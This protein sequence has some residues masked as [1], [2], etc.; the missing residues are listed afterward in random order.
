MKTSTLA[1]L[2]LSSSLLA[3][4]GVATAQPSSFAPEVS[5]QATSAAEHRQHS[6]NVS[7]L[8]LVGG[9]FNANYERLRGHHGLLL[10]IG[11][12][13]WTSEYRSTVNG[14]LVEEE[15][16]SGRHATIGVGYRL[17]LSGRQ[18]GWFV[19]AMLHH[20]FGSAEIRNMTVGRPVA[21]DDVA[22][23]STTLTA[24]VGKRWMLIGGLNLT[25]RLGFGAADRQVDDDMADAT[26]AAELQDTLDVPVAVDGE[27]SLGWTF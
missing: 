23:R 4:A 26:A 19:G 2:A 8:G 6:I 20:N 14:A 9:G 3:A 11:A 15:S 12:T 17:H 24:H 13:D 25:A 7:P 22:Y 16:V 1:A 21:E 18:H 10:E 27:L 5:T